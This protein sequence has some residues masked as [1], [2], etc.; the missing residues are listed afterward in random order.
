MATPAARRAPP[1]ATTTAATL[2]SSV[3]AGARAARSGRGVPC[4]LAVMAAVASWAWAACRST[5]GLALAA[6]DARRVARPTSLQHLHHA[7]LQITARRGL[8]ADVSIHMLRRCGDKPACLARPAV[9]AFK[10]LCGRSRPH[11]AAIRLVPHHWLCSHCCRVVWLRTLNCRLQVISC[12]RKVAADTCAQGK[13]M[14]HG[15]GCEAVYDGRGTSTCLA[16]VVTARLC[17]DGA[18]GRCTVAG[19]SHASACARLSARLIMHAPLAPY[20]G[21]GCKSQRAAP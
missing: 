11:A 14:P 15:W 21:M 8:H 9:S 19:V 13:P 12:C 3:M 2:G 17:V 18:R 10:Q 1:S 7:P 16:S 20:N 6:D 5:H 4:T